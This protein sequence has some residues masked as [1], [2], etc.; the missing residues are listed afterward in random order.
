MTTPPIFDHW[1]INH[2]DI[3]GS[4][5]S[6]AKFK[7]GRLKF[8]LDNHDIRAYNCVRCNKSILGDP[9]YHEVYEQGMLIGFKHRRNCNNYDGSGYIECPDCTREE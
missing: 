7:N 8:L 9:K 4:N 6:A 5:Y 1:T 3:W 2:L